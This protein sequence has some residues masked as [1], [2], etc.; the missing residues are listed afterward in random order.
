[1]EVARNLQTEKAVLTLTF[2]GP[3]KPGWKTRGIKDADGEWWN[4]PESAIGN[5]RSGE[6]YHVEFTRN[7]KGYRNIETMVPA[8][9]EAPTK[10]E[11][12]RTPALQT[13]G[14]QYYRPTSPA[15]KKSMFRCACITAAIKSRQIPL[16]RDAI[17]A[18]IAE[19]DAGYDIGVEDASDKQIAAV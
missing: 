9:P 7:A 8:R 12:I 4:A 10:S 2:I 19:V 5:L 16:T 6:T 15:D 17:A 11:P 18:A 1:M 13:N 14:A 3:Q